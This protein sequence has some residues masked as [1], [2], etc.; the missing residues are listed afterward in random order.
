M[1]SPSR[2]RLQTASMAN[3]NSA[4]R[5][6]IEMCQGP[7]R[8]AEWPRPAFLPRNRLRQGYCALSMHP[9]TFPEPHDNSQWPLRGS[10]PSKGRCLGC[11]APPQL[12]AP[13]PPTIDGWLVHGMV[14]R[15]RKPPEL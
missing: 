7:A 6:V 3:L 14:P 12:E 8:S 11:N 13:E 2:T 15:L 5:I 9:T 10:L 4:E 1:D